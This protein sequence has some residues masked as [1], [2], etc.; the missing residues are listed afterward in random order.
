MREKACLPRLRVLF[1]LITAAAA[2]LTSCADYNYNAAPG[3]QAK[4][5]SG[6]LAVADSENG[7][8]L[9]FDAPFV[10]GES[11]SIALGQANFSQTV[12]WPEGPAV[13]EGPFGMALDSSGGLY[14]ADFW[15]SRVVQFQPPFATDMDAILEVGATSFSEAGTPTP[16]FCDQHPSSALCG[17]A[18]VAMDSDGN[19]WVADAWNGR[20]VEFR[21]PIQQAM[22]ASLVVGQPNLSSIAVCNGQ[23]T[24]LGSG[25]GD[26][27]IPANASVLCSPTAVVFDQYGDLWISDSGNGRVLEYSPPFSS[28]MPAKL[29]LGYPAAVGMNSLEDACAQNANSATASKLCG[30]AKLAF[31]A[32]GNLW[33]ADS[34]YNRVL[35]FS[36]P[37]ANGMSASLVIGQQDFTHG[38]TH[39]NPPATAAANTLSYPNGVTL[40]AN[41]DLIVADTGDSRVLIFVPPFTNGMKASAVIGQADMSSW[42]GQ[43]CEG[44]SGS[45]SASTLCHPQGVLAF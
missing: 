9:I 10:T 4:I 32:Q 39:G 13:L 42:K 38:G 23:N 43:G 1:F 3:S 19:L 36:P 44:S 45:P 17:A 24:F 35:R 16:Y 25:S 30:P 18:S 8:V 21:A 2:L 29:E 12:G 15:G 37:F 22:S 31:D 20:V 34:N 27:P 33:V 11:A 6:H 41:G 5:G 26:A 28:S 14:V 7:R 40:D